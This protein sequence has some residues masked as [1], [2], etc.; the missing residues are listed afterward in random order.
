LWIFAYAY[1]PKIWI[2]LTIN[3]LANPLIRVSINLIGQ[4]AET[5]G[6]IDTVIRTATDSLVRVTAVLIHAIIEDFYDRIPLRNIQGDVR[7]AR[8]YCIQAGREVL[9]LKGSSRIKTLLRT[10][11]SRKIGATNGHGGEQRK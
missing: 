2:N 5:R 10:G 8:P 3:I 9:K 1:S 11:R 6:E 4:V 7:R